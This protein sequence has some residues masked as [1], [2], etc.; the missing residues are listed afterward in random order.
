MILGLVMAWNRLDQV[1]PWV[2]WGIKILTYLMI[3]MGIAYSMYCFGGITAFSQ[4]L[5]MGV[6]LGFLLGSYLLAKKNPL[7]WLFLAEMLI[8]MGTLMYS[9]DKPV[10]VFQQAISLVFV[11]HGFIRAIGR[12]KSAH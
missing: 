2:D 8:S 9:Q 12:V 7:G 10:L 11:I 6:T 1:R 4:V 5:E 3:A